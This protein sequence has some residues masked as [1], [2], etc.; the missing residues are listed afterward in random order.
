MKNSNS[1]VKRNRFVKRLTLIPYSSWAVLFILVPLLFVAYYAFTDSDFNFTFDNVG[2]FFTATTD[3]IKQDGSSK[4]VHTYLV[5]FWRSLK[6]AIASTLI[7]LLMGYPLAYIISRAK[8][9]TQKVII[10][11]IM[12]PMWMNF[13]IRTYAWMTI[14][15]D[16]GIL[17][18]ILGALG[19]KPVHIIGT[20]AAVVIGMV[21]DYLPYMILPIYSIMAKMDNKLIE[22]AKDLGCNSAGV[23][24]RVIWPLSLPGVISGITMVLIPS[25]STFYISQKL[26]YGKF[27]LIGDAIEAQYA[28]NNLHFAA[29]IAFILMV[30]LLAGMV[31]MQNYANKKTLV[32]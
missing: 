10:T 16:A 23:L 13:L 5:I 12:I 18:G 22:A 2:R 6:L 11:L 21:Y 20:E 31:F 27:Y 28:A 8:A 29:A 26:G 24:R 14:L 17:N 25:I 15:Q 32:A 3:I 30:I 1:I 4:E 19:I 9:R 7:C